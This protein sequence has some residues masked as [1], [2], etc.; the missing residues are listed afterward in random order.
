MKSSCIT[1]QSSTHGMQIT[2]C[3][4]LETFE[5]VDSGADENWSSPQ[6][7]FQ[8]SSLLNGKACLAKYLML[9]RIE[10]K[11]FLFFLFSNDR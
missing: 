8:C 1:K 7:L 10:S 4:L 2:S 5:L 9:D 11:I 3:S 6:T